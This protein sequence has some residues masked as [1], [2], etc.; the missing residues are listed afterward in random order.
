M[1][2]ASWVAV[3][4]GIWIAAGATLIALAINIIRHSR[5]AAV[6]QFMPFPPRRRRHRRRLL[7][8]AVRMPRP[9]KIRVRCHHTREPLG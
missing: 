3:A 1:T 6:G 2:V 9:S 5:H 8:R 4:G 7:G